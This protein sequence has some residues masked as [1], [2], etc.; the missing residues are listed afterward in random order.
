MAEFDLIILGGGTGGYVGAIRGAQLGLKVAVVERAQLGGTCLHRGCIPSKVLLRSA[1]VY[2][3]VR[4]AG[5][6]GVQAAAATMDWPA[7]MARKGRVVE[8]LHRGVQGLLKKNGVAVVI[9]TGRLSPLAVGAGVEV[10]GVDTLAAPA[11]VIATGSRPK[12]LGLAIDGVQT[13]TS[14]E[15]LNWERLPESV[16]IVGGGAI[17]MEW[18][19]LYS[20]LGVAVT[21]LEFMPRI[22]PLDDADVAEELAK[23]L[24]RRKVNIVTGARVLPETLVRGADG[25]SLEYEAADGRQRATAAALLVS[26]GRDAN[27]EGLG[28][29]AFPAVHRERGFLVTDTRQQTGHPGLYAIGDVAGG[30]LAHVASHQ[31]IIAAEHAAGLTPHPLNP[32]T[33]ARCTYSRPEVAAVGL[34]EAEALARGLAVRTTRFPFRNIGKAQVFGE[35]DGFAK[36]VVN[37]ADGAVLGVHVIGPHATDLISEM[38]LARA[39]GA[40]AATIA[41]LVHPHPTL[42]EVFGEGALAVFGRAIHM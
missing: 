24:R 16:V 30:G 25:V 6:F 14:D 23:L 13:F 7:V 40:T 18:A 37:D 3:T 41:E 22:L 26:V 21:V 17:G 20:D 27:T 39:A 8:N 34:S 2:Q 42:S 15:A 38:A 36:L 31:G 11:V 28:L 1:E 29:E 4:R 32:L 12:T 19:S 9:G 10:D 33:V 35:I 5:E